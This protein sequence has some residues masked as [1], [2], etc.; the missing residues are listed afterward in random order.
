MDAFSND[1]GLLPE[2]IWDS[3]DLPERDLFFGRPSGSAMPLVW[4]HA[5]RIKLCR[6]LR[7]G[8]LF[9]QPPQTARRYPGQS[10]S[11]PHFPWRFSQKCRTLPVGKILR[12]E[13][14]LPARIHWS[15]DGWQSVVDTDTRDRGLGV[16]TADLP[17]A[18][19]P[20]GAEV[21]FTVYW[22][23]AERWEGT[24]FT[25]RVEGGQATA[26]PRDSRS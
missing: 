6:S 3:T 10:P 13:T 20:A 4:A 26:P 24:D 17:T 23:R 14:R 11:A 8:R 18:D 7:E 5:E 16:H 15:A 21:V 1:G 2:Q 19:L 12:V 25:V 22:P 9:D